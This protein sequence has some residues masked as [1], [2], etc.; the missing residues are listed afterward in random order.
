MW[1]S[2]VGDPGRPSEYSPELAAEIARRMSDGESVLEISKDPAMPARSTI[3]LWRAQNRDGFSD[4]YDKAVTARA[5]HIAEELLDIA[6][7][8][9][10]DWMQRNDPNNEGF[11][12]NGE[13]ISRSR[14]RV[15]TR[16]WLLSKLLPRYADRVEFKNAEPDAIPQSVIVE[17][18]DARAGPNADPE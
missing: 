17:V 3:M 4:I 9:S 12:V 13:N 2:P 11:A 14:L 7:N 5:L 8:G 1:G 15:D 6:D 10:N 16:K 18:V